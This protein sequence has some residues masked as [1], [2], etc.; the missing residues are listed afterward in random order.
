MWV[1]VCD[2]DQD[3]T[4]GYGLLLMTDLQ[5]DDAEDESEI[6]MRWKRV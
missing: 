6:G 1:I 2:G 4:E 3:G 5:S